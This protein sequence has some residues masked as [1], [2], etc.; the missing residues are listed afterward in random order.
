MLPGT[1]RFTCEIVTEG[2]VST[3]EIAML[4]HCHWRSLD[5]R[6]RILQS[7]KITS[8]AAVLMVCAFLGTGLFA[9]GIDP[10]PNA[11]TDRLVHPKTP[12]TPPAVN[13]VFTDP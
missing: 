4:M 6:A 12:M 1:I 11:V 3:K 8:L 13:V 7:D 9:Q 10:Y 5:N 2:N